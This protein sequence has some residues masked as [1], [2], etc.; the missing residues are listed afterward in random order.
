MSIFQSVAWYIG[1]GS[2]RRRVIPSDDDHEGLLLILDDE[3]NSSSSTLVL[4]PFSPSELDPALHDA[5]FQCVAS[6]ADGAVAS[7]VV[8]AKAGTSILD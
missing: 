8:H 3:S 6:N 1:V 7:N 4:S 5:H 2:R